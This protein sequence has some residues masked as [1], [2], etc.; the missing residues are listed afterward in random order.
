LL[1]PDTTVRH[2]VMFL[3][4]L[5]LG[6]HPFRYRQRDDPGYF[7]LALTQRNVTAVTGACLLTRREVFDRV[8]GFD[9]AHQVVNNDLDYCLKVR[10]QGLLCIFTPHAVLVHHERAS[11]SPTDERYDS[12]VFE[13]RWRNAF[14]NGDPYHHPRLS[15]QL[16]DMVLDGE[17]VEVVCAGHPL[18]D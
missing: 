5:G 17:P 1:Y 13:D 12:S 4:E 8:G 6:R 18:F 7:G 11:R 3:A 2:A 9:E 16:D 15:K 14:R 10:S